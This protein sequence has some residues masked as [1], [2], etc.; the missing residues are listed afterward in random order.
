MGG[1]ASSHTII[2]YT[3]L[4][5]V[6]SFTIYIYIIIHV[7]F[8]SFLLTPLFESMKERK[9]TLRFVERGGDPS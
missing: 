4:E 2:Y 3:L 6:V 9:E 8:W 7:T 1:S 5:C